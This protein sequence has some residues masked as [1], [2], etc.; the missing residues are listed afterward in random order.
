MVPCHD[1]SHAIVT[2]AI[3]SVAE[4]L[5]TRVVCDRAILN[6]NRPSFISALPRFNLALPICG[7]LI[8]PRGS[9]LIGDPYHENSQRSD[10]L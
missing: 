8:L 6:T 3:S 2:T 9:L 4:M 1:T 7:T 10:C 5:A